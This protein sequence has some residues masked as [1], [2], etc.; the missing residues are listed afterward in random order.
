VTK[1][2]KNPAPAEH[3]SERVIAKLTTE[4]HAFRRK[5]IFDEGDLLIKIKDACDKYGDWG[6]WLKNEYKDSR[7]TADRH[8]SAA[9]LAAT[10]RTVRQLRVPARVIYDLALAYFDDEP[11]GPDEYSAEDVKVAIPA[12]AKADAASEKA[13]TEMECWEVVARASLQAKWGKYPDATLSALDSISTDAP[14]A[15]AAIAAL[16]KKRP[17]TEED[18]ARIVTDHHFAHVELLYAPQHHLLP[19]WL[20]SSSLNLLEAVPEERRAE[21]AAKLKSDQPLPA[22][23]E[24]LHDF[25]IALT[26]QDNEADEQ[27]EPPDTPTSMLPPPDPSGE[28][29]LPAP[30]PETHE[31]NQAAATAAAEAAGDVGG[32]AEIERLRAREEELTRERNQLSHSNAARQRQIDRLEAELKELKA[33]TPKLSINK[34]AEA[35]FTA[36]KKVAR[37]KAEEVIEELCQ[38]LGIDPRKV[39]TDDKAKAA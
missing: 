2:T 5:N 28:T 27:G 25:V 10:F 20:N 39:S 11:A 23:P 1:A 21:I 24:D 33:D 38:K 7:D 3:N 15:K 29:L 35:L 30:G 9:R 16:Q 6:K 8:I 17:K 19:R 13:L 18:A 37:G 22:D 36:L 12:L 4:F 34:L 32:K 14:W 31:T 26:Q